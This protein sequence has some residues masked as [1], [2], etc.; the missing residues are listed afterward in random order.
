M[1]Y[2]GRTAL[3]RGSRLPR[4]LIVDD[5][6][7]AA[8]ALGMTLECFGH[9]VVLAHSG[10]EALERMASPSPPGAAL[11]DLS[12]PLMD[13]FEVARRLRA[14]HPRTLLVA[15]TGYGDE[16]SRRAAEQ[17]G[18]HEYVTKPATAR[19]LDALLRAAMREPR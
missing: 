13:G 14:T 18:F 9:D 7:D 16:Q 3:D 2:A 12:L 15:L 17:A 6:D 4:V 5:D 8:D 1:R 10:A 19:E 11:I